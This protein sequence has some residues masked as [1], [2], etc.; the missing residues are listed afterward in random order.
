MLVK[1]DELLPANGYA[2]LG[3]KTKKET[4]DIVFHIIKEMNE[5]DSIAMTANMLGYD[6]RIVV[7]GNVHDIENTIIMLNPRIVRKSINEVIIDEICPL[8]NNRVIKVVRPAGVTIKY[9]DL[10]GEDQVREYSGITAS[11]I[12]RSMDALAGK[13]LKD[14][15]TKEAFEHSLKMAIDID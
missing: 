11:A 14:I 9:T 12:F 5:T 7:V 2:G 6:K 1:Y 10:D 8:F 3:E 15:A 13:T 4:Y